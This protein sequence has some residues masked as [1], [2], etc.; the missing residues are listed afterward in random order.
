MQKLFKL[1][2][3]LVIVSFVAA[4]GAKKKEVTAEDRKLASRA[5]GDAS[6]AAFVKDNAGVEKA[7]AIATEHDPYNADYWF[8]LGIARAR[9]NDKSG[10]R[11]AFK[12]VIS[13]CA[14]NAKNDPANAAWLIKQIRPMIMLGRS[15][16]AREILNRAE[17]LFPNNNEVRL[18]RQKNA[19]GQDA[20][21]QLL[22]S[23]ELKELAV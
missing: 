20:I 21:D 15:G 14:D 2:I 19:N 9:L 11:T 4:C 23:Q 6:F 5:A 3:A 17:K 22:N 1:S 10:A 16:D 18:F 13:V 8:E 12:N 7:L